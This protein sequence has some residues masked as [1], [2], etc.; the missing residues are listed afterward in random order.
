[1]VE[2]AYTINNRP[3]VVRYPRGN[4][5]GVDVLK[6]SCGVMPIICFDLVSAQDIL[7]A[8]AGFTPSG[9]LPLRGTA[10]PV[11]KGRVVK[12]GQV[13]IAGCESTPI[14][15]SFFYGETFCVCSDWPQGEG[16][17]AV[18][19]HSTCG[20]RESRSGHRGQQRGCLG[21]GRGCTLHEGDAMAP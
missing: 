15:M 13:H 21:R 4:G 18:D 6:V 8:S 17:I 12:L 16:D 2:T 20:H 10:L 3:S 11:G 14:R 7:G 5:Y 19:R 9:E 1:M